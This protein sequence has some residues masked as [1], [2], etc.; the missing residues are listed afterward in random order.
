MV[1]RRIGG[2][3]QPAEE[4]FDAISNQFWYIGEVLSSLV[5]NNQTEEGCNA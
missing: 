4:K 2:F 3:K 1:R 5:N